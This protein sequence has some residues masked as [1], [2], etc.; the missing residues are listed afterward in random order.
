MVEDSINVSDHH[1]VQLK[2]WRREKS[3]NLK[4]EVV[5]TEEMIE[6]KPDLEIDENRIKM[7]NNFEK[8][9]YMINMKNLGGI[10]ETLKIEEIYNNINKAIK[11]AYQ[12]MIVLKTKREFKINWWSKKLG[13]IKRSI[14]AKKKMF[15]LR[16]SGYVDNRNKEYDMELK[17]L[18]KEFRKELRRN[19]RNKDKKNY[20]YIEKIGKNKNKKQFWNKIRSYKQKELGGN[21]KIEININSLVLIIAKIDNHEKQISAENLEDEEFSILEIELAIK[22]TK[23]SKAVGLDGICPYWLKKCNGRILKEEIRNLMSLIYKTRKFPSTFI[24]CKIKPIIKDYGKSRKDINNIRP[25]TIS[26]SSIV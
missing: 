11:C 17:E 18:K 26:N 22:E 2:I 1:A 25:I 13:D 7:L 20:D 3:S 23:N 6:I 10:E 19:K 24:D 15:K 5:K 8:N 9:M 12:E 4:V 16:N 21:T 14:L